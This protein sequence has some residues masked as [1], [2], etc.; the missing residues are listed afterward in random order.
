MNFQIGVTTIPG[1]L[2]V[3]HL[4]T[5]VTQLRKRH[6]FDVRIADSEQSPIAAVLEQSIISP[7]LSGK[8]S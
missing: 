5:V 1:N 4:F 3:T 2:C 7:T 8:L 6:S